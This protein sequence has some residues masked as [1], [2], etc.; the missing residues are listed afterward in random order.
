MQSF[1][2]FLTKEEKFGD[3]K[4]LIGECNKTIVYDEKPD[5]LIIKN[6]IKLTNDTFFNVN[7]DHMPPG[8][9]SCEG[10]FQYALKYS[11]VSSALTSCNNFPKY[12]GGDFWLE[13]RS[14]TDLRGCPETVEGEECHIGGE[15]SSLEGITR[16]VN[17]GQMT[18][19]SPK[20]TSL[21]NIHKHISFVEDRLDINAP[22]SSNILGLL[23]IRGVRTFGLEVRDY[24]QFYECNAAFGIVK[25]YV[26][27]KDVFACQ[28][29]LIDAGLKDYA[30]L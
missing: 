14:V 5:G 12:V 26:R 27:S 7:L 1:K 9:L 16:Y 23:K 18:I 11:N 28:E 29:E 24:P 20:L 10:N 22:I 17:N 2:E 4:K 30:E 6:H 15:F 3:I 21:Q 19:K 8:L 25:K 13:A